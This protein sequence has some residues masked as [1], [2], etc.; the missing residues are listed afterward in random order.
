VAGR[1]GRKEDG[2][3]EE[4]EK[5]GGTGKEEGETCSITSGGID[6]PGSPSKVYQLGVVLGST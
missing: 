5:G 3:R 2:V 1:G 6:A 4:E